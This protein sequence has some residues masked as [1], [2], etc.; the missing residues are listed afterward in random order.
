MCK[1]G[2][3]WP[4]AEAR[5]INGEFRGKVGDLFAHVLLDFGVADVGEDFCDPGADLLHLWL[6]HPACGY[7]RAAEADAAALHG[8]EG[9]ERNRVFVHGNAGA[10][11]SFF[12][13]RSGDAARVDF[14][15]KR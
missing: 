4:A 3:R 8:R 11:E 13:I 7:R 6:A 14:D 2:S 10:V 5:F 15:E 1:C 9:I 12:G